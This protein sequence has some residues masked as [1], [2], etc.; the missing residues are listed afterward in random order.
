MKKFNYSCTE[1]FYDKTFSDYP[2]NDVFH[3]V[4]RYLNEKHNFVIP[5]N[6]FRKTKIFLS[7]KELEAIAF[8]LLKSVVF[9]KLDINNFILDDEFDDIN[10]ENLS[11][12]TV[13][14]REYVIS[15][16]KDF[17]ITA[18]KIHSLCDKEGKLNPKII[19]FTGFLK[20]N[21]ETE[22]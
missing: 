10:M 3:L 22:L 19:R 2:N 14:D 16:E 12:L 17:L 11:F 15:F 8:Y 1:F 18:I 7:G 6:D 5:R 4:K 21:S 13:N 9:E 20:T